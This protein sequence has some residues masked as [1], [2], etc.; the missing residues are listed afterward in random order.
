LQTFD[1]FSTAS[2]VKGKEEKRKTWDKKRE[3]EGK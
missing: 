1:E 2:R 3:G